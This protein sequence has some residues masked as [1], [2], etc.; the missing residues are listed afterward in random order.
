MDIEK[1][2][3]VLHECLC[4]NRRE[5]RLKSWMSCDEEKDDEEKLQCSKEALCHF[6]RNIC[7]S[8]FSSD[9]IT[10]EIFLKFELLITVLLKFQVFW[11]VTPHPPANSYRYFAVSQCLHTQSHS[12]SKCRWILT[13]RHGVLLMK[14][15]ILWASTVGLLLVNCN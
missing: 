6:W 8:E 1:Q 10:K 9:R 7:P 12:L 13:S 2:L 15:C 3:H 14:T 11:D 5:S 4:Y